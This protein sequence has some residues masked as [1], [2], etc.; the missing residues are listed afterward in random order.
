MKRTENG[1]HVI[2]ALHDVDFAGA[3]PSAIDAAPAA[4]FN[5]TG[6][7]EHPERRPETRATWKLHLAFDSDLLEL[8]AGSNG[9]LFVCA[10]ATA[11][12][13]TLLDGVAARGGAW[14]QATLVECHGPRSKPLILTASCAFIQAFVVKYIGIRFDFGVD[15]EL[16]ILGKDVGG[17]T[18]PFE[19]IITP[20]WDAVLSAIIELVA[21]F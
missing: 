2:D 7:G 16:S 21:P 12:D 11:A 19:L 1:C 4:G 15:N 10:D 6:F 13:A 5:C 9:E 3:W 18:F 17:A 20:A 8:G 14:N